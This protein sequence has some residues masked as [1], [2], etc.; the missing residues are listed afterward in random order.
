MSVVI[1]SLSVGKKIDRGTAVVFICYEMNHIEMD[2]E[3]LTKEFNRYIK[4]KSK[5]SLIFDK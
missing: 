2:D 3:I 4:M 5:F 1:S